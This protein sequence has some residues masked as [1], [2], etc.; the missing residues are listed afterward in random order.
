MNSA[1]AFLSCDWGT[2]SFR[3]RVVERATLD[4]LDQ[5]ST[6]DG[7]KSF[8][9]GRNSS[10]ESFA[11]FFQRQV[12]ALD[13]ARL[14]AVISGMA[15]SSL[16]WRELPY[17][18]VP[19]P[20]DGSG[21][22]STTVAPGVQLLSGVRTKLDVLRGEETE[23]I[24][25]RTLLPQPQLWQDTVVILPGTHSKHAR[26]RD[27]VLVDFCTVM[28]G[29][30]FEILSQHSVLRASVDSRHSDPLDEPSFRAG[31]AHVVSFGLPRSLFRVRSRALLDHEPPTSNC[32]FLSGLL[33]GVEIADL[34]AREPVAHL[35]LTGAPALRHLYAIALDEM[36]AGSRLLNLGSTL[37]A[38][39]TLAAHARLMV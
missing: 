5:A 8:T 23:L 4:V 36:G 37:V 38:H 21:V 3:L 11:R 18:Q 31:V 14:P 30:L 27:D 1:P 20:L 15:S 7:V 35:L 29:E 17:A 32:A 6:A 33:I 13:A 24:G 9:A 34:L 28:T 16:G 39:A 26:I 25:L 10:G 22:V 19:F 12:D 2:T